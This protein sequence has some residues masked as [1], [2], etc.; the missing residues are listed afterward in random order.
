MI[1]VEILLAESTTFLSK[2]AATGIK[3]FQNMYRRPPTERY[4]HYALRVG[5][6]VYQSTFEGVGSENSASF[7]T[8]Y[9]IKKIYEYEV[10]ITVEEFKAWFA[11]YD[12]RRYDFKSILSIWLRRTF[13]VKFY[14]GHEDRQII[15]DELI[16][17]FLNKFI[18]YIC[19]KKELDK[20]DLLATE[21]VLETH[22]K[23]AMNKVAMHYEKY[24]PK[25]NNDDFLDQYTDD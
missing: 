16:I 4:N 10:P 18:T 9:K 11:K 5:S 6:T 24:V 12:G 22:R 19:S 7:K 14:F 17:I 13:G 8:H 21:D 2:P 15:C 3:M 1:K 20:F 25:K 23:Q